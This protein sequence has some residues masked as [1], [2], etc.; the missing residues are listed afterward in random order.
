LS[1]SRPAYEGQGAT[2][3]FKTTNHSQQE[4][5]KKSIDIDI[6]PITNYQL[7]S[8]AK[9]F[10]VIEKFD[11]LTESIVKNIGRPFKG[12]E[13]GN[14]EKDFRRNVRGKCKRVEGT[15][16]E[17]IGIYFSRMHE[18][19][20]NFSPGKPQKRLEETGIKSS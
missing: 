20:T 6:L 8:T 4:A 9:D 19:G 14:C 1:P 3:I 2:K 16:L 13:M 12:W 10:C 17:E 18:T 15:G 7:S 5:Q 11:N